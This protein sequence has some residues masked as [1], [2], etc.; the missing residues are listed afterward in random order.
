MIRLKQTSRG[1]EADL[2]DSSRE[3][4]YARLDGCGAMVRRGIVT[5][6]PMR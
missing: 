6:F 4:L 1:D 5:S 2:V 3:N